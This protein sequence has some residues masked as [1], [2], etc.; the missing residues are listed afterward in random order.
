MFSLAKDTRPLQPWEGSL[1]YGIE[2]IT[3]A[4]PRPIFTALPHFPGLQIE[5]SVYGERPGVSIERPRKSTQDQRFFQLGLRF[6]T[7]AR[8]PS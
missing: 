7:R 5:E 3:V 6:S 8:R 2:P 4:G 1:T